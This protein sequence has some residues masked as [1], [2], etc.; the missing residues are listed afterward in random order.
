MS[1]KFFFTSEQDASSLNMN[2]RSAYSIAKFSAVYLLLKGHILQAFTRPSVFL[3][4][5]RHPF[6]S[7]TVEFKRIRSHIS[8]GVSPSLLKSGIL[9][10][11]SGSSIDNT[12]VSLFTAW[13]CVTSRLR[14][15]WIAT[16]EKYQSSLSFFIFLTI[17]EKQG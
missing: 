12:A 8:S 10:L 7:G 2:L 16:L 13:A 14:Y 15:V 17:Y 9:T 6:D 5:A 11:F 1:S 4:K 3:Y